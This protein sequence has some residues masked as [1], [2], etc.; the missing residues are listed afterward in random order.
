MNS[1]DTTITNKSNGIEIH[2]F[3]KNKILSTNEVK[4]EIM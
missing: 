1:F 2:K 4:H 3:T